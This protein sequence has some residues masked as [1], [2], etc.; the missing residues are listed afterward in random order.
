MYSL[1]SLL[2]PK[3]LLVILVFCPGFIFAQAPAIKYTTP[4]TY[5]INKPV[6][7]LVPANTGGAVPA[8]IYGQVSTV[9]DYGSASAF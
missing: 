1:F 3:V 2:P 5:V 7:P 4:H 9:A 6:T 8:A